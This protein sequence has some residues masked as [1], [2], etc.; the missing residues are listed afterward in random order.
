MRTLSRPYPP[1]GEEHA[2]DEHILASKGSIL[3]DIGTFSAFSVW[4]YTYITNHPG[5]ALLFFL[6]LVL[7]TLRIP[8]AYIDLRERL[9][10]RREQAR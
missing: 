10:R 4:A 7:V 3:A 1:A 5:D 6:A 9:H 2:V 8:T